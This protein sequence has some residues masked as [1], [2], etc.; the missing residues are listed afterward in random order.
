MQKAHVTRFNVQP[1]ATKMYKDM[2][3]SYWWHGM[4]QDIAKYVAQ[5]L[6]CQRIKAKHQ[7]PAGKLHDI[8]MDLVI[9]FANT[10]QGHDAIWVIVDRINQICAFLAIQTR[11]HTG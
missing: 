11:L 5:F 4:K 7:R 1:R 6:T 3:D 10:R 8:S 9:G 2:R